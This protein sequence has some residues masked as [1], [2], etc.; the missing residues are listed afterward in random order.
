[1]CF[2]ESV[3]QIFVPQRALICFSELDLAVLLLS[4]PAEKSDL[5]A[6]LYLHRSVLVHF[7]HPISRKR[8]HAE[9]RLQPLSGT[10]REVLGS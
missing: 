7:V 10:S 8:H 1:M 6:D 9:V 4:Q 2:S 5:P 3:D